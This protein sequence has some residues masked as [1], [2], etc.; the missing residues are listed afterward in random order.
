MWSRWSNVFHMKYISD[1]INKFNVYILR[2]K[3]HSFLLVVND[4][5]S[6]RCIINLNEVNNRYFWQDCNKSM[7]PIVEN[8]ICEGNMFIFNNLWVSYALAN[9]TELLDHFYS[10]QPHSHSVFY[11]N[12]SVHK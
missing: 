10:I 2:L 11:K 5:T 6:F 9:Q 1:F 4:L 8:V 12:I 7:I 3:L